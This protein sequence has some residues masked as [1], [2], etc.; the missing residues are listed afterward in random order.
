[1]ADPLSIAASVLAVVTAA[2]SSTATLIDTIKRYKG[3]DK[4]LQR[5]ESELEDLLKL[6]GVIENMFQRDASMMALLEGPIARC[7]QICTD[8]EKAMKEFTGKAKT[9]F[10]D[11]AKLEFRKGDIQEFIDTI[12]N[13]RSTIAVGLGAVNLHTAKANQQLIE[14]YNEMVQDTIYN[15]NL[16][17]QRIDEKIA[18][19]SQKSV[20]DADTTFDLNDERAVTERCLRICED[21]EAFLESLTD[22]KPLLGTESLSED[23]KDQI[24]SFDAPQLTRQV[25]NQNRDSIAEMVGRLRER[26][27]SL[28]QDGKTGN[29]HERTRLKQELDVF[30]SCLEVCRV[31]SNEVALQKKHTV[32][33]AIADGDSD[34]VV[35]TTMADLFNVKKAESK[36]RSAQLIGSMSDES[37]QQVSER[38]YTSRFG[39]L[40]NTHTTTSRSSNDVP[41][42]RGDVFRQESFEDR[43]T[44]ASRPNK[45]N[46]HGI[47]R[48]TAD[49]R[50]WTREDGDERV[51]C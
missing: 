41:R 25:L 10:L 24:D 21:A 30:K 7:S 34:Q 12:T 45:P 46:T 36:G 3:R 17:L 2:V 28:P 9:G 47:R 29:D 20:N 37:L 19:L 5:L 4:T 26:L 39:A 38:R 50:T 6:L 48:R 35:V 51:D 8:F 14:E 23:A 11:W 15:L 43:R 1:M 33:E 13:Y 27:D 31:A 40:P 42:S 22:Q 16:R 44:M 32:G 49:E 18:N